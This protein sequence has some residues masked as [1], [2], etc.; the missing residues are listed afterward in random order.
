[1]S[2]KKQTHLETVWLSRASAARYLDISIV[3]FDKHVRPHVP[4]SVGAGDPRWSKRDLDEYM[5][6]RKLAGDPLEG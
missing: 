3:T 6:S 1:M 5:A 2:V 4:E